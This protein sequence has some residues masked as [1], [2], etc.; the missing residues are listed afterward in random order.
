M[1]NTPEAALRKMYDNASAE[2]DRIEGLR[3]D[4]MNTVTENGANQ[5]GIISQAMQSDAAHDRAEKVLHEANKRVVRQRVRS[6]VAR[7][8]D[9]EQDEDTT[10]TAVLADRDTAQ[11]ALQD[12]KSRK[13]ETDQQLAGLDTLRDQEKD[14]RSQLAD[15]ADERL[16]AIAVRDELSQ[17]IDQ[18]R[19]RGDDQ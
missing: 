13:D 16:E 14:L 4:L 19:K 6:I 3:R 1:P 12:A 17:R 18:A 11:V 8:T 5:S 2:I 15:L 9:T 7:G 10:L